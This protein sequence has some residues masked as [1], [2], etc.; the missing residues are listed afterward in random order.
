M[1]SKNM[2]FASGLLDHFRT[3]LSFVSQSCER[4]AVLDEI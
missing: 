4:L 1:I 3:G 2:T